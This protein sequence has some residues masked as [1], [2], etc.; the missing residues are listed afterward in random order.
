MD[1]R[2]L[3]PGTSE[4][5]NIFIT[6][7]KD[8]RSYCE[9]DQKSGTF[10]L[11]KV[12]KL[13]FPGFYGFIPRTH[14]IDAEPLDALVLSS[15]PISQ[16]IVVQARPIGIIRLSGNSPDDVLIAVLINDKLFGKTQDL[17]TLNKEELDKLKNFLE[18]LKGKAF[19]DMFDAPHS[20]RSFERA[21]ELYRREF[22]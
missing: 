21:V 18:E 14:H 12:L 15:E 2:K 17:L 9:L 7:E 11:K 8:S 3:D 22:E 5:I 19:Q 6:S 20:K 4:R 1:I 16:G 13:P 10:M